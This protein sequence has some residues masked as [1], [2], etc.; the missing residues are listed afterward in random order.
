VDHKFNTAVDGGVFWFFA[1]DSH[2]SRIRV[3]P[4][5]CVSADLFQI[6]DFSWSRNMLFEGNYL[7][8]QNH[9]Y[10]YDLNNA[11]VARFLLTMHQAS[12]D[13]GYVFEGRRLH[14]YLAAGP[15]VG[16]LFYNPDKRGPTRQETDALLNLS[17]G[18][19]YTIVEFAH[20]SVNRIDIGFR[21]RYFYIWQNK[22]VDTALNGLGLQARLNLRW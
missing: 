9:G 1:Y 22:I 17:P 16:F 10:A 21:A 3:N 4:G 6:A 8:A 18:V 7:F 12:F 13:I 15:G 11:N 14:P 5:P 2:T 19:D 20:G